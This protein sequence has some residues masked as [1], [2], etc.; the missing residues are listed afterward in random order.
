MLTRIPD[1]KAARHDL[2]PRTEAAAAADK[3]DPRVHAWRDDMADAALKGVVAAPR[4]VTPVPHRLIDGVSEMMREA[5]QQS[6]AAVSELLPGQ[7]FDILDESEGWAWGFSAHDHYVGYIS[8]ENL[9]ADA[10]PRTHRITAP[11]ALCFSRPDIK[12]D[13]AHNL[14]MNS[15]VAAEDFDDTFYRLRNG[16]FVHRR[17]ASTL[18]EYVR[19]PVRV[20]QAFLGS[21]YKWGG[22]TRRGIDCSGLIQIALAACDIAA[23]RDSDQQRDEL[24][25]DVLGKPLK[26]G[27][28]I[29]FPGHVGIMADEER[30][31]HANA[32][33]MTTLIEPLEDVIDRLRSAHAEPVT[34]AR[35]VV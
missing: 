22:R 33:W 17:H 11:T 29:F 12:S 32:Y 7:R 8:A 5:P 18:D 27:D 13:V 24:G 31:L 28:L 3:P 25:D 4:Y 23:P 21:P 6:A 15:E 14:P 26:R 30:L 2:T 20:A 16:T 1:S 34:G 35:R 9:R 10:P 19:D